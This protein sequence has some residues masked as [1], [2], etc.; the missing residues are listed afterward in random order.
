MKVDGD[1]IIRV[2]SRSDPVSAEDLN[3]WAGANDLPG[4]ES[5]FGRA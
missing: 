5:R 4:K 3:R 2:E 1:G